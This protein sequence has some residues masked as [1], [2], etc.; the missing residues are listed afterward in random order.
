MHRKLF[1]ERLFKLQ[2]CFCRGVEG[3][4]VEGGGVCGLSRVLMGRTPLSN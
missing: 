3:G 4:G 1:E 2:G